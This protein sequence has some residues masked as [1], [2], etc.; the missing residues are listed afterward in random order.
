M[1][2]SPR[3]SIYLQYIQLSCSTGSVQRA[4][5]RPMSSSD[6]LDSDLSVDFDDEN[7]DIFVTEKES[8]DC[9]PLQDV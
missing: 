2:V 6:D 5:R 4:K 8:I 9:K 3:K 1:L 7:C